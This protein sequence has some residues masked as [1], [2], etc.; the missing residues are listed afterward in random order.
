MKLCYLGWG[1]HVHLERWAGYFAAAGHEVSVISVSGRGRYPRGVAQYSLGDTPLR[2]LSYRLQL[3]YLRRLL[4]RVRPDLVHVHWASFTELVRDCWAGPLAV[5]AW[6]SDIYQLDAASAEERERMIAGLRRA[7]CITCD[8]ED[9]ARTI[10]SLAGLPSDTVKIVQW[11]VDTARFRPAAGPTRLAMQLALSNRP[12]VLSPRNFTPLYNLEDIIT[13]FATVVRELPDAYLLMKR[14]GG[15]ADYRARIEAR[16]RALDLGGN[17]HVVGQISYDDMPDFYQTGR[18][19]VS[20]PSTDATPMSLLEGMACGCIPVVSDLP[21]LREWVTDGV[22]GF[23]VPHHAPQVLAAAIVT[24]VTRS[25]DGRMGAYNRE[26]VERRAD[27]HTS[28]LRMEELYRQLCSATP[29]DI[30]PHGT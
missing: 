18:V 25:L 1:N 7:N 23:V 2:R 10:E 20:V 26:L 19:M 13:A 5:T 21:S 30:H 15:M 24:A 9:L 12:V 28:M 17:V 4:R 16:I 14:Y 22:N 29:Q 11:G 3:R 27:Q 6:G 8:S